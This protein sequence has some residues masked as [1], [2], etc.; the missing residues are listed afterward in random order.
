MTY[1]YH[2]EVIRG[3]GMLAKCRELGADGWELCSCWISYGCQHLIFKRRVA[4]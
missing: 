2:E 4:E 1:E 3:P